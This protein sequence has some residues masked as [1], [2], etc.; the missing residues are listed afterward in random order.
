MRL[1]GF[2]T[3]LLASINTYAADAN[4]VQ[5]NIDILWILIAAAMVFFMQGGFTALETGLIRAKNSLNVAIKNIS[6]FMVAVLSFW[7]VGFAFMFG[8]SSSGLIG[9]SGFGLEGYDQPENYAF[10]IFQ[11]VFAGTAA[12]IVSGAVAERMKFKSYLFISLAITAII[13]PVSGHWIWGSFATP[14]QAG[15]LEA[16]GFFDFAGSTVVHSV[17]AWIGL[18]GVLIL[19]PRIGRFD[20]HGKPL[21]IPPHNLALTTVGVFILWFGWFGFNGGS[22]LKADADIAMI[23]LNTVLSPAAAG[24]TCLLL[25]TFGDANGWIKIEKILNGIIGG[26]VGITAGCALVTPTGAIMLGIGSG[27]ILYFAEWFV[28]HVLKADDPINAIAAHGF[29]GAWGTIALVF[30]SPEASLPL[31]DM[32]AQLW[33]QCIGVAAVFAWAFSMGLILFYVLNKTGVLRVSEKDETLGLNV[34]EHGARSVWLDTMSAMHEIVRDGDLSRRVEIE[35]ATEAGQVAESFNMLLEDLQA[36]AKVAEQIASGKLNMQL[37][38]R[39]PNDQLGNSLVTMLTSLQQVAN[40]LH[41]A[42]DSMNI[43]TNQLKHSHTTL[44]ATNNEV[45]D[46]MTLTSASVSSMSDNFIQVDDH[47]KALQERIAQLQQVAHGMDHTAANTDTAVREMANLIVE[48]TDRIHDTSQAISKMQT[49][50]E[51]GEASV[52]DAVDLINHIFKSINELQSTVEELEE[53]STRVNDAN[54]LIEDIAFQT[55]LLALNA[56][57]EAARAGDQGR[58]FSVVASEVRELAQRSASAAKDINQLIT[59]VRQEISDTVRLTKENNHLLK[60]GIEAVHKVQQAFDDIKHGADLT[61]NT[62]HQVMQQTKQQEEAKDRILDAKQD[63]LDLGQQLSSSMEIMQQTSQAFDQIMTSQK[64]N[65]MAVKEAVDSL[66]PALETSLNMTEQAAQSTTQVVQW[67]DN[68]LD[69]ASF[70]ETENDK[71]AI[72]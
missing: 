65:S 38:S 9:L 15:W 23:I 30:F 52:K 47:S 44:S 62:M 31:G 61:S 46:T 55:N 13:Y 7:L 63:V 67:S 70:F 34:T 10:F 57:V 27:L 48:V 8:E 33:V 2:T 5:A 56:S 45:L 12:T 1:F 69:Q 11:L 66:R 21:E 6:D 64:H 14:G 60:Q 51:T 17:G 72:H 4:Q 71:P 58:G 29:A 24:F 20:K 54:Q 28:L 49:Q 50:T 26:L 59:A 35:F 39:G 3:L 18:A 36:K 32:W 42:A 68:L 40:S 25:S 22:T 41:S 37:E 53:N 43:E 19:G 16:M